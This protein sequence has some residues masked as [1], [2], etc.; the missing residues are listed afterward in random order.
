MSR[1]E[2]QVLAAR[3][4]RALD[5][6]ERPDGDL[7]TLVTVLERA[8]ETARFEVA[9]DVVERE[10][11]RVRPRLERRRQPALRRPSSRL[12]LAFGA[13]AAAAVA[14]VVITIV[15]HPGTD[16]EANAQ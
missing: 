8:T 6:Q 9:E 3:L 10:L 5:G 13:V 15:R 12:A 4:A 16:L 1:R 2:E 14:V 11:A 7:A